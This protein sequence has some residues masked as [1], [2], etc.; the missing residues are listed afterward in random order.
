[1][2]RQARLDSPGTLHHVMVEA[3]NNGRLSMMRRTARI[4][5]DGEI[6]DLNS[7]DEALELGVVKERGKGLVAL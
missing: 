4:L 7:L 5:F 1:M 3:L 6:N 2:P